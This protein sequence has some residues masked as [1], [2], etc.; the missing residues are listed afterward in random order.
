MLSPQKDW[1]G[2]EP[3]RL[4][5]VYTKLKEIQSG[6]NKKVSIADLIV[7]GGSAAIEKAAIH[8]HYSITGEISK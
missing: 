4:E 1:E 8:S 5:K 2:N 7:L 3:K 6:L